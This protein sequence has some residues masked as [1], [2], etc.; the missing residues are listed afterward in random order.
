MPSIWYL[1][2]F[3]GEKALAS[4]FQMPHAGLSH[5]LAC[6]VTFLNVSQGSFK[7]KSFK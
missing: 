4:C 6:L 1:R 3:D 2:T 7:T 5:V